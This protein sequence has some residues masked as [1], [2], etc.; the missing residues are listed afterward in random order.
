MI[1]KRCFAW[2]SVAMLGLVTVGTA[3]AGPPSADWITRDIGAPAVKGS[4]DVDANGVWTLKGSG[5]DIFAWADNFQ[6]ASQ[7]VKG[8]GSITARLLSRQGGNTEWA[9]VG[10]MIRD[11]DTDESSNLSLIMT[12]GH[13]LHATARLVPGEFSSHFTEVG[14]IN[15]SEKNMFMRLQRVGN[16]IAGFYS[17]DGQVW[18]QPGFAPQVLPALKDEALFGLAVCSHL[19]GKIATAQFDQVSVQPGLLSA[20]GV[21]A[22][23]A[24]KAVL[25]QWHALPAAAGFNLYRGPAKATPDQLARLNDPPVAGTSFTDTSSGLVNGTP[26][27]YGIAPVFKNADGKLVEGPLVVLPA[28]PV[29]TPAGWFGTSINEGPKFGSVAI[30]PTSGEITVSGAGGDLWAGADQGYFLNQLVQGDV[31]IT[32]KALTR[33]GPRAGL[34]ISEGL[35]GS[36]RRGFLALTPGNGLIFQSRRSRSD[37]ADLNDLQAIPPNRLKTPV[38]IRLTRKGRILTSEFSTDDGKSFQPAGDPYTF[39]QEL[40]QSVYVG[41]ALVGNDRYHLE[42]ARFTNLEVKKP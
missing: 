3:L 12:P 18:V 39:D 7:K 35:D 5:D 15:H 41:L 42:Q 28:T 20:Y 32:V 22:S 31:Q 25:L 24:D 16:E 37:Y 23:G 19:D 34:M 30:D 26:V 27:T 33:P 9:K 38:V 10:L 6:F 40:P 17:R 13:G 4:T 8:D 36:G 14:P 1:R 29:A 2:V 21:Q 11:N